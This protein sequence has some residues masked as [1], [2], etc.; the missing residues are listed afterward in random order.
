MIGIYKDKN[1]D[2][3]ILHGKKIGQTDPELI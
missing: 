2:H 3:E 1:V